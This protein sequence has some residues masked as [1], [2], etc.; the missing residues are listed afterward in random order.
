MLARIE[1]GRLN[2]YRPFVIRHQ[3]QHSPTAVTFMSNKHR[4]IPFVCYAVLVAFLSLQPGDGSI[5]G[6]FDKLA[7]FVTYG[8]FAILAHSMHLSA[9]HFVL[10]CIGIVGYGGLLEV[11][12]SFV[13]GREMSALD[14]FANALGV[15]IGAAFGLL[16]R[17]RYI[18][19][20]KPR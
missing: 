8:I 18:A 15:A 7:H 20:E 10:V 19:Q 2:D 9:R 16:L 13:P 14:L 12:Q 4:T 17:T 11:A 6:P 5:V 1:K 3:Y